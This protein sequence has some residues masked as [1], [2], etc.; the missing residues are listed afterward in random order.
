MRLQHAADRLAARSAKVVDVALDSGFGDV[1]NFNHAF[2]REFG[3][4][5]RAFAHGLRATR[6]A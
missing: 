1:S 2:K 6:E 4:S 3:V 5:P